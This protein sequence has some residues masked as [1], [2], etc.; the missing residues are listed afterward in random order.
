[1]LASGG[2]LFSSQHILAHLQ[3]C[4]IR[5]GD[6]MVLITVVLHDERCGRQQWQVVFWLGIN[7]PRSL[8]APMQHAWV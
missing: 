1:V 3:P 5:R 6:H 2:K 4:K 8:A 7:H